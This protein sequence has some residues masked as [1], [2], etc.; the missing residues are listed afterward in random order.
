MAPKGGGWRSP[1]NPP[2]TQIQPGCSQEGSSG[3]GGSPPIKH[4]RTRGGGGGGFRRSATNYDYDYDYDYVDNWDLRT[5]RI[6]IEITIM[7]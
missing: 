1:T 5:I 3:G 2:V 7:R 4:P 6:T